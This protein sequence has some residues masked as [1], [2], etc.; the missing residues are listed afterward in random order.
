MSKF[1]PLPRGI[2]LKHFRWWQDTKP[3]HTMRGQHRKLKRKI[4]LEKYPPHSDK[5]L[6]H[7]LKLAD[8]WD[9]LE[10]AR[11]NGRTL[12]DEIDRYRND[13]RQWG[14]R[15]GHRSRKDWEGVFHYLQP[16]WAIS[17]T[18]FTRP[19]LLTLVEKTA[20]KR[21]FKL[22]NSVGTVLFALF[23][24]AHDR[25]RLQ[26]NPLATRLPRIARPKHLPD[27]NPP[28]SPQTRA[29]FFA[30]A[31]M[32]MR[33]PLLL[34]LFTGIGIGDVLKL[35]RDAIVNGQI[36]IER[37][38][39]GNAVSIPMPPIV[40][41]A[42]ESQPDHNFLTLLV[43]SKGQ[44]WATGFNASFQRL[45]N[46]LAAEGRIPKNTTAYGLRH[47][48]GMALRELGYDLQTVAEFLGQSTAQMAAYYS[49]HADLTAKM[50]PVVVNLW[51]RLERDF[52]QK[53]S[54]PTEKVS[55]S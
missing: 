43:N 51:D 46:R 18:E 20:D 1:N 28:W 38:K 14:D 27:A 32:H 36:Q 34:C 23:N 44:P 4:D 40:L 6:R 54:N 41:K 55:N 17:L 42:L 7:C 22:A 25:G 15:L 5:L 9:Q 31:P 50:E 30:E 11:S 21:G 49:R 35:R 2:R 24:Y 48:A 33:A 3:P 53:L 45:R 10:E 47:T 37:S 12:Q 39:T 16:L 13:P 29:I 26:E 52:E 19:D 8:E